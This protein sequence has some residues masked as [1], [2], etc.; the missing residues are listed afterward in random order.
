MQLFHI[1]HQGFSQYMRVYCKGKRGRGGGRKSTLK[2]YL[3]CDAHSECFSELQQM[4]AVDNPLLF[5]SDRPKGEQDGCPDCSYNHRSC[6]K[7]GSTQTAADEHQ[8][9]NK[10]HP[11]LNNHVI[12][13]NV[14][15]NLNH[16]HHQDHQGHQED[17]YVHL[18]LHVD[19]IWLPGHYQVQLQFK[20]LQDHHHHVLIKKLLWQLG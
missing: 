13:Q 11:W 16:I 9:H 3:C 8:Q 20:L 14:H 7:D 15:V 4:S 10:H 18:L 2:S 5:L 12:H 1:Q 6:Y 17:L 19:L